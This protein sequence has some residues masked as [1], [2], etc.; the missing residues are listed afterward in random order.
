MYLSV[1]QFPA[2]VLQ[3]SKWIDTHEHREVH[4]AAALNARCWTRALWGQ[5][6]E[7]ALADCNA[8]VKLRPDSASFLNSRGLVYLRKGDF[9]NAIADYDASLQLE[10]LP[11]SLYGRGVARVRTGDTAGGQADI[12]AA[13]ALGKNIAA[14]ASRYGITP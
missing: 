3:F 4:M 8:A 14:T 5:E 12:A 7:E 6:I 13:T 1:G 9:K 2:A 11:W 10:R